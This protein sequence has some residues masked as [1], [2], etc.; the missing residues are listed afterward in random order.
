MCMYSIE[1]VMS[2]QQEEQGYDGEGNE[3]KQEE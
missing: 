2:N 3:G 1:K